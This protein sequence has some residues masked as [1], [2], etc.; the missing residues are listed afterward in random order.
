M[1]IKEWARVRIIAGQARGRKLK[2]PKGMDTRP[3]SGRVKEAIFNVLSPQIATSKVLDVFAGTG[4]MGIEALSRGAEKAVFIEKRRDA[5]LTVK[6]NL[7]AT[8]LG[9]Y[10][11]VYKG[12]FSV[13]L[14]RLDDKFD[15]IFI[16]PPYNQ[17]FVQPAIALIATK[18]LLSPMGVIVLETDAK[19]KEI[20]EAEGLKLVKESVYGD[21]AVLYYE[22]GICN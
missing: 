22:Q 13:V 21:T 16:D 15:I 6:E 7:Q 3:T 11:E 5:W 2:A 8:G 10:A 20:I 1:L 18:R 12:D 14:P 17:G 4:A 9:A 19:H